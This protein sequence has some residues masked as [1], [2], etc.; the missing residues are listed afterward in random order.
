MAELPP[1]R[2]T[3]EGGCPDCAVRTVEL[4]RTLDAVGDD[5]DWL[6]RDYDGF[7]AFMLED[8]AA[9][10]PQRQRWTA[11][12]MEVVLVEVLAA[13]LDRLSDMLDRVAAEA[14][15]ETARRPDSVRRHL[16]L[17]G[18][19]AAR[20]AA[21]AG[22][23]DAGTA[24]EERTALHDL[25]LRHPEFMEAAKDDGPK[26]IRLQRRMVTVADHGERLEDH[27]LVKRATAWSTWTGTWTTVWVAVITAGGEDLDDTSVAFTPEVLA[28]VEAFEDERGLRATEFASG[29]TIRTVLTPYVD[30]YRMAGQE[31][32]L[33]DAVP[34]P[35]AMALSIRVGDE[36]FQSEVRRAVAEALG[37]GSGGFFEPGRLAFG[38]DLHASDV[39]QTLMALEGV[40]NVCINR[41]KRVGVQHPDE[42]DSG[43]IALDG[44]EIA[45]LENDPRDPGRGYY[46]LD[47]HGGRRG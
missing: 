23:I 41:F 16:R 33:Q 4:P 44:L 20:R 12:D 30:A 2:L 26:E 7:R 1:P 14:Y 42:S 43:L 31:V 45:V 37:T 5:F 10:T 39:V 18:Y 17:I 25:W 47:L 19:D 35:V 11:A 6:V 24:A 8:L 27:P 21:A 28:A 15:L 9:R 29:T 38:E 3:F 32:V 40:Q 46:R 36:Y 13:V 34:V 22:L